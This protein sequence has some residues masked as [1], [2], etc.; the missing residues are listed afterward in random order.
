MEFML[1]YDQEE[2]KMKIYRVLCAFV[3]RNA[4]IGYSQGMNFIAL[5]LCCVLEEE[6]AFWTF[7]AM[8][9]NIRPID[10]YSRPPVTL[11]GHQVEALTLAKVF[12]HYDPDTA[13]MLGK[14]DLDQLLLYLS[15]K[16]LISLFVGTLPLQVRK[17][18]RRSHSDSASFV[19]IQWLSLV[20]RRKNMHCYLIDSVKRMSRPFQ[21]VS[22][23]QSPR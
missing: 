23:L 2:L 7:C 1:D 16:W 4:S 6:D 14:Q 13:K 3:T 11:N 10:Y 21:E 22:Y 17:R 18:G 19:H 9:E 15:P 5:I 8:M 12:V 20:W